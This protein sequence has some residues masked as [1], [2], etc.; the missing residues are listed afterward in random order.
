LFIVILVKVQNLSVPLPVF[1]PQERHSKRRW[2][3]YQHMLS[4]SPLSI[5]IV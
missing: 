5:M 3:D 2:D 1:M 4:Q